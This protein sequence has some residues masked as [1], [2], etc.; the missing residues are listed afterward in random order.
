MSN[1]YLVI[2]HQALSEYDKKV[3]YVCASEEVAEYAAG[4]LNKEYASSG[5]MLDENNLF[6]DVSDEDIMGDTYHYYTVESYAVENSI[7][8]LKRDYNL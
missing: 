2:Q 8:E 1:V 7:E 3:V 5:V 4:Q 6:V